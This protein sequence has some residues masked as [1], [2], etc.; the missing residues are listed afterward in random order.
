MSTKEYKGRFVGG[1]R[2]AWVVETEEKTEGG[3]SLVEVSYEDGS[4]ERFSTLMF[5][6]IVTDESIDESQLRDKRVQP[7]VGVILSVLRDWGVKVG[8]LPY[9]SALLN[10]SLNYNVEEATKELW[11]KFMPRPKSLDDVD[12]VTI[13][14]VLKTIKSDAEGTEKE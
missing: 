9:F 10:Q 2:I 1:K 7:L 8:E 6:N 5:E 13:D 11:A 3:S 14:R 4:I 12:T